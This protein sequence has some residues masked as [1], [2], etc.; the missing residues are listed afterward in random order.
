LAKETESGIGLAAGESPS[1][2]EIG[3]DTELPKEYRRRVSLHPTVVPLP[4]HVS[5]MGVKPAG[6]NI[7]AG[8]GQSVTLPLTDDQIEIGLKQTSR[9]PGD[10]WR[11]GAS[12]IKTAAY[13]T[14]NDR[15]ESR[16][17]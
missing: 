13:S 8:N 2:T 16:G 1:L 12:E 14:K 7:T 10:G 11:N 4:Q 6:S 15:R 5:Q 3:K 9:H 17:S